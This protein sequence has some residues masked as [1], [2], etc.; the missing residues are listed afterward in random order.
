MLAKLY[1]GRIEEI[2]P[3]PLEAIAAMGGTTIQGI[4]LAVLPDVW[5][6]V[7]ANT[8]Y[9]FDVNIRASIVLGLVGAGGLGY[10]L[11]TAIQGLHY[12]RAIAVICI[13]IPLVGTVELFSNWLRKKWL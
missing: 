12:Q 8:L 9:R 4:R 7:V 3:R 13:M 1:A 2:D 11:I 10:E 5:P 6:S